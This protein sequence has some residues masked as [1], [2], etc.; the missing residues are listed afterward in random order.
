MSYS[1]IVGAL[2]AI[3]DGKGTRAAFA[4]ETDRLHAQ[5]A[6]ARSSRQIAE[7]PETPQDRE[8]VILHRQEEQA[9]PT[10]TNKPAQGPRIVPIQPP[11]PPRT[12]K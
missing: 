11:D 3:E 2:S 12:K 10:P 6:S 7:R 8:L 1:E 9:A 5:L 4:T